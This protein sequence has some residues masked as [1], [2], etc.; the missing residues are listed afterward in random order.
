MNLSGPAGFIHRW[1]LIDHATL[2]FKQRQGYTNVLIGQRNV[3][4]PSSFD[5]GYSTLYGRTSWLITLLRRVSCTMYTELSE[6]GY[7]NS[8]CQ[9]QYDAA[10]KK[11][12]QEDPC[13]IY[14]RGN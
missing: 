3:R 13:F 7:E 5:Y 6:V 4:M 2:F 9:M 14:L 1:P 10:D 8:T 11:T 12:D